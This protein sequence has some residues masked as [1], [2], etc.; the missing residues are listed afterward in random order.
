MEVF[1]KIMYEIKLKLLG[2]FNTNSILFINERPENTNLMCLS[3]CLQFVSCTICF[4]VE[5]MYSFSVLYT[6]LHPYEKQQ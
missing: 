4:S 2:V 3:Q 1:G 6:N 5:V